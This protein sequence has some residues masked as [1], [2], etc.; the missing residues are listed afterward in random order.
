VKIGED[1]KCEREI[2]GEI[3]GK[4]NRVLSPGGKKGKRK[5]KGEFR[6][7]ERE[8]EREEGKKEKKERKGKGERE[9]L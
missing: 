3:G 7:E 6:A 9:K 4:R 8:G 1:E 2:W 5:R